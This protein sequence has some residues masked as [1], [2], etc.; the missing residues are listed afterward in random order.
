M[1]AVSLPIEKLNR[2]RQLRNSKVTYK[3]I[4]TRRHPPLLY[5]PNESIWTW[6]ETYQTA[7]FIQMWYR[8][9]Y[10]M[11]LYV[12]ICPRKRLVIALYRLKFYILPVFILFCQKVDKLTLSPGV[13]LV[14]SEIFLQTELVTWTVHF[15]VPNKTEL[16]FFP[17]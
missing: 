17:F 16:F 9:V 5:L 11:L 10:D 2:F 4:F 15:F 3:F 1:L 13:F 14:W 6:P 8:V 12:Q 7:L